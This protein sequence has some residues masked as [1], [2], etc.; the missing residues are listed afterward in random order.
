MTSNDTVRRVGDRY[1][2][3]HRLGSGGGG[4]VWAADDEVLRRPVAVKAVH[5]PD[6]VPDDERT[7]SRQRVLREARAA[8]R[9]NH[10]GAVTV[11]DVFDEEGCAYIVMELVEAPSLETLVERDGPMD[12]AHAAE[13][14]LQLVDALEAAH[15]KGIVH[16]DVKPSNVL[17]NDVGEAKLTDFGIATVAGDSRITATGLVLGSPAYIAP[18]QARDGA[19][20]AA[21]DLWG[22][23]ATLYYAVEGSPAFE[24][25]QPIATVQAVLHEDPRPAERAGPL[26]PL[27]TALLH[28]DPD[29]RPSHGEVRRRLQAVAG[30]DTSAAGGESTFALLD[31]RAT[32]PVEVTE[33]TAPPPDAT[34]PGAAPAPARW[35][36][37]ALAMAA[38]VLLVLAAVA[39]AATLPQGEP[40]QEAAGP[41]AGAEPAEDA[42]PDQE[43]STE[44]PATRDPAD[45]QPDPP[46]ADQEAV[47]EGGEV[48]GDWETYTHD[49][50]WSIAHPP[51]WE[52]VPRSGTIV[53][54]RDPQSPTYMRVDYTDDP[55]ASAVRAWE[56]LSASFAERHADYR[57]LRI[58]PV[59]F[60]GFD[61]ALWEY[62]Y[63][64]GGLALRAAN[65]GFGT[66]RFG[67]ALNFQTTA[68]AWDDAQNLHEAFRASFQPASR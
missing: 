64:Q 50:G 10:P 27:L 6:S 35:R 15:A 8:A 59:T 29:R 48:P 22:L 65:L 61:G 2:L 68:A 1:V 54:F 4:T 18:E 19:G 11:F 57:E 25:G 52:V 38:V 13:I 5:I 67:Q 49:F 34:G 62:T 33:P 39:A 41:P 63:T 16:R 30:G 66:D 45:E 31:S 3:R 47:E 28:K 7:A 20:Q 9:L 32:Q 37:P 23:G 26:E 56:E 53:D 60:K 44:D 24:R 55:P 21:G 12:D 17:V 58:E 51:R 40:Q 36:R 14:G 43:P 46:A 42:E